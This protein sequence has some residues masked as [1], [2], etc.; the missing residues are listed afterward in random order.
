MPEHLHLFPCNAEIDSL[1]LGLASG[2]QGGGPSLGQ[3]VYRD[4]LLAGG[5]GSLQFRLGEFR[6]R[7][8]VLDLHL[9][10][11]DASLGP[12]QVQQQLLILH[13]Q[14]A[15]V[16]NVGSQLGRINLNQKIT[17]LYRVA[18]L[19]VHGQNFAGRPGRNRPLAVRRRPNHTQQRQHLLYIPEIDLRGL[20][21]DVGCR[22]GGNPAGRI[23]IVR[24][25][26]LSVPLV[27][28]SHTRKNH[29]QHTHAEWASGRETKH[30]CCPL[31]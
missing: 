2:P 19:D 31:F 27:G 23:E 12:D 9:K 14:L 10:L 4:H 17:L 30:G 20:E 6:D 11:F 22:F 16:I 21:P 18:L 26:L 15:N 24:P 8:G 29:E 1:A 25:D 13:L 5:L 28:E 3:H 7:R